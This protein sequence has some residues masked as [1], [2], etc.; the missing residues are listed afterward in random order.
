MWNLREKNEKPGQNKSQ[1]SEKNGLNFEI[2]VQEPSFSL[3]DAF[4][5]FSGGQT[6]AS[7]LKVAEMTGKNIPFYHADLTD[8][9]TIKVPFQKVGNYKQLQ[10]ILKSHP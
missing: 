8:L 7:L 10:S 3:V 1:K 6:P 2:P 9:D 4:I 5:L